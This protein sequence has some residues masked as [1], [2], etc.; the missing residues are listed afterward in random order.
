VLSGTEIGKLAQ[1][2]NDSGAGAVAGKD[3]AKS[4]KSKAKTLS[5]PAASQKAVDAL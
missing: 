2:V 1:I 3:L 5:L 4:L